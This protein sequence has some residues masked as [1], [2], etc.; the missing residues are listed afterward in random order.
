M[1]Y[2]L[3]FCITAAMVAFW[4]CAG[5]QEK[6][7]VP[8]PSAPLAS[9]S[10]IGEPLTAESQRMHFR[11]T[12]DRIFLKREDVARVAGYSFLD[13][14]DYEMDS[15]SKG[16]VLRIMPDYQPY[17]R[18]NDPHAK[19]ILSDKQIDTLLAMINDAHN[20][21]NATAFCFFPR[22]CFCFYNRNNE[23]IGFY[24]ICFECTRM[25]S[26]PAFGASKRGGLSDA[27]AARLETFCK[28]L[29][30]IVR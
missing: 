2:F 5:K 25:E 23:I 17:S 11:K 10:Q 16:T 1:N 13:N 3:K 22:N 24:E 19:V 26:L 7:K 29:Q 18:K 6:D 14:H 27:V 30:M 15:S 4:S 28:S 20:Y 21:K 9:S 8:P 12:K